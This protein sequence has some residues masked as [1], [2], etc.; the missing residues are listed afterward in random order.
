[1]RVHVAVFPPL[2]LLHANVDQQ[3]IDEKYFARTL[4]F[5]LTL[6]RLDQKEIADKVIRMNW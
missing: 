4:R 1:M 6:L 2:F 5:Q 3:W